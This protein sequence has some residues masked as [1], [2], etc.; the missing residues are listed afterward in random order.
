VSIAP[1]SAVLF[2][3][4][5]GPNE[6]AD[7]LPFMRNATRGRGIPDE[8]LLEVS[9]HYEMFGGRSPINELNA[10]L[11]EDVRVELARRG[12]DVP[13][14]IGNRNWHPYFADTVD[15]LVAEGHE[16]VVAV[17]TSAYSSYSN[18]RQYC[19]DLAG[20]SDGKPITI[21]KIDPFGESREFVS[22]NARALVEAVRTLRARIGDQ[23]LRV[24][25]VTHSIPTAMNE[26]SHTGQPENRYDAQHLRVAGAVAAAAGEELGEQLTW[27]LTFC[28]RSG[29]PHVPWLEPDVNDRMPEVQAEG[30]AG[31]VA[32]PIGFI[33]DHME[34]IYDLDT[35]AN[36]TAAEL[37]LP[38][39]RAATVGPDPEFV[40]LLVDRL[41][42]QAAAARG[43][44][45]PRN[46]CQ[47]STG[48]C[49]LPR[50]ITT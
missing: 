46:L 44:A 12:I 17:A 1:Y 6:S 30:V 22:A 2:A 38:Y 9:Q 27:E 41:L 45:A 15:E 25:F 16:R 34:V 20:A 37:G 39:E 29:S 42:E 40:S 8:R 18:C 11:M 33:S 48:R 32:A 3:S 28:S 26:A 36:E 47:F 35:Q 7:V 31:V 14:V 49:C 23:T 50:P 21:D 10:A 4:Y 13:V 19:E 24:L 5:G 43:E